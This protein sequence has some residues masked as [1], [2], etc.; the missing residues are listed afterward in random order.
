MKIPFK[1]FT[2]EFTYYSSQLVVFFIV[3]IFLTSGT[4]AIGITRSLI[5]L[6]LMIVQTILLASQ[7]HIPVLRFLFSLL[8]PV[9]YSILMAATSGADFLETT[10]ILLWGAALYI[11]LFQA[12]S[13][14]FKSGWLKRVAETALSLGSAVIFF[15]F[16]YYLDTRINL[17]R[18]LDAGT[19]D[20]EA[21]L[22]ALEIA[23][24]P[25]GLKDFASSPQ[26]LFALLGITSF[27]IM[28]LTARMRSISLKARIDR[29]LEM[30]PAQV[31]NEEQSEDA[32]PAAK[33]PGAT[34]QLVSA[35]SSDIIGFTGLSE[36]MGAQ[37]SVEFL[38]S[39]YSLW[40][41]VASSQGG[42]IIS[43][44]GDSVIILFGLADERL[45]PERALYSAYAFIDEMEDFRAELAGQSMPST[46]KI[47]IGLH[48][49]MVVSASLGPPGE[50]K[51]NVFGDTI[52][53]AARLDSMCRELH[54]NLLV[55]HST[56]RRLSLESQATLEHIGDVLLRQS[57]R[58]VPVYT[59]K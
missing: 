21:Y 46:F 19:L 4:M 40:T 56:F 28:L 26:H 43:I 7:G 16:Y 5:I 39:Y 47:S 30:P 27:D 18:A 45:N 20:A 17:K 3:I 11:G 34:R 38:N 41:H 49:G 36:M 9:G 54:Q 15:A 24:F 23:N 33:A 44:S 37:R 29:L 25:S 42:R 12:L 6:L 32:L 48:T 58:P 51:K 13:L 1:R 53:I 59:R 35:I 2:G 52:A 57:T 55:S 50:L 22:N 14:S 8:M 31:R 10:N